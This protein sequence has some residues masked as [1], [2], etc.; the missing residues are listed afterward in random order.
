MVCTARRLVS[1]VIAMALLVP[2][3]MVARADAAGQS[4]VPAFQSTLGQPTLADR[5]QSTRCAG[6]NARFTYFDNGGFKMYGPAGIAVAS[7]R[8][9][10][11]TDY[12]GRRVLSWPNTDALTQCQSADLVIGAGQL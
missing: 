1:V 11:V 10:F 2:V 6:A 5:T 4:T 3:G 9:V 12:G 8:R 7:S